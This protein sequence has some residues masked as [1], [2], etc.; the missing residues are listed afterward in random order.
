[1]FFF[2][3]S[4]LSFVQT[5]HRKL[6]AYEFTSMEIYVFPRSSL[7][8][9]ENTKQN[10]KKRAQYIITTDSEWLPNDDNVYNFMSH[11]DS[12]TFL[13][14]GHLNSYIRTYI[15]IN[16][17]HKKDV[18]LFINYRNEFEIGNEGKIYRAD[19]AIFSGVNALI[20]LRNRTLGY[21]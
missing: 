12:C 17:K 3:F 10:M 14:P 20:P 16:L 4:S 1:M 9:D 7:L 5:Q 11:L 18:K 8:L 15:K 19:S 13:R 21:N 6:R 2:L